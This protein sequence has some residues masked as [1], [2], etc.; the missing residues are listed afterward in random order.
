[1]AGALSKPFARPDEVRTVP[2]GRIELFEFG[3]IVL[4][5]GTMEP[6][7][8]WAEHVK[9]I[10][11]TA[12]CQ[13]HHV[14]VVISGKLVGR[15]DDGQEFTFAAEQV[16]EIQPGHDAWVVGDEPWITWDFAGMRAFARPAPEDRRVLAS[17]LFVDIVN[18]T[19]TAARLGDQA[20]HALLRQF[21]EQSRFVLDQYRGRKVKDTGDGFLALFDGTARAVQCAASLIRNVGPLGIDLRCGV[22]A[23]E[24]E[25]EEGDVRGVT[26][27]VASRVMAAAGAGE[28]MV[29][30]ATRELLAGSGL[31]FASRGVHELKGIEGT[32]ELYALVP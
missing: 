4:G 25:L 3:D 1:M 21:D 15:M 20:W 23:G 18:S 2:K 28:V 10:A 31:S 9:P 29:T 19:A 6:G 7:W 30:G 14:G 8:H 22:H 17:V 11:A 32:R 27:H 12:S 16:Y 5:R 13:Y 24:V 26:V